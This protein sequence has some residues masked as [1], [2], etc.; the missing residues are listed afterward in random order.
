MAKPNT[1]LSPSN[2]RVAARLAAR[3]DKAGRS[4]RIIDILASGVSVATL[5]REEGLSVRRMRELIQQII[6][7]READPPAGFVQLQIARLT[8]AMLISHGAMMAGDM[9]SVDRVVKIV[10]EL[11][12]YHGFGAPTSAAP[13][14]ATE[15]LTCAPAMPA[16]TAPQRDEAAEIG[17]PSP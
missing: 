12:R 8:D 9:R 1:P 2:Q 16:L 14:F 13:R 6:A 17:I 3:R 7:R 11:D 4:L 15:R 5:A 10:R